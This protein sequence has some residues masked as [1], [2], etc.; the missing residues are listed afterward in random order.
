MESDKEELNES[1]S[2]LAKETSDE[3]I[4]QLRNQIDQLENSLS[5]RI[6]RKAPFGRQ[7]SKLFKSNK[8]HH[9]YRQRENKSPPYLISDRSKYKAVWDELSTTLERGV[10]AVFGSVVDE[11]EIQRD[12]A[13][14]VRRLET[15]VGIKSTDIIL[16]IGCGVGRVGGVLASR[17]AKWIGT[18]ISANMIRL[19]NQRLKALHNIQLITLGSGDLK[20]IEDESVDLVCCTV[21][22]MHLYE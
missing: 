2:S 1:L 6:G 5:L 11:D 3:I 17:R 15:L 13:Q 4:S 7:I 22:F 12:G 9:C 18:D 20:E 14:T 10:Q 19:A 21:V 16:E 8:A